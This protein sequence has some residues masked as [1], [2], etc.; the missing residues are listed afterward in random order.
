MV[1]DATEIR[2]QAPSSLDTQRQTFSPYKHANTMKC[3][4]GVTPDCY[5]CYLSPM[6]G[7]AISDREIVRQCDVLDQS[8]LGD[9]IMVDKVL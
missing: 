7:G 8:E 3:L 1:L 5:I 2:I 6:Y 9:T 4:V